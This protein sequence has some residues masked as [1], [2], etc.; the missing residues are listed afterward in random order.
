VDGLVN[1]CAKK[2]EQGIGDLRQLE[3]LEKGS[4]S[5]VLKLQFLRPPRKFLSTM[6]DLPG[7]YWDQGKSRYF[8][9]SSKPKSS[10]QPTY[11]PEPISGDATNATAGHSTSEPNDGRSSKRKRG[12]LWNAT[13]TI[14]GSVNASQSHRCRQ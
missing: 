14:R 11:N 10:P 13:E 6:R 9:L 4:G 8:P 5:A 3:Y 12:V 7:L 1:E 2:C